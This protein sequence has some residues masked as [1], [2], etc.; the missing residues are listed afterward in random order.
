MIFELNDTPSA[1]GEDLAPVIEK[2]A[3]DGFSR[4]FLPENVFSLARLCNVLSVVHPHP[5]DLRTYGFKRYGPTA[6]KQWMVTLFENG[7]R[8][9]E[10]R[11]FR[12]HLI[13]LS[14]QASN[15]IEG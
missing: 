11:R 4:S 14:I 7:A 1:R 2:W 3:M 9:Y 8:D 13:L 5:I 6:E 15:G 12:L 10:G